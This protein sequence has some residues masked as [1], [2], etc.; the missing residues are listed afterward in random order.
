MPNNFPPV[1]VYP[2]G[3]DSDETLY[4]VFN[5][6]ET[7][8]T[9][10]NMPWSSDVAVAP[11]GPDDNEI[12]ANNGFANID[13]E[14]FYY[15]G[16]GYDENNK[17]NLLKHCCRNL[18]GSHTKHC[19]AGV[20]VRGFVVAEHHNQIADAIIKIEN[21]VGENFS[22]DKTTLDWKIRNLQQLPII[23]D[24]FTC[25]DVNFSF[26]II[27][28]D[29]AGG[30]L[31][32]YSVTITGT[33]TSYRL[34]FGDGE[35]TTSSTNGTHQYATNSV[36]DPIITIQNSKCTIVQSPIQRK[37]VKQPVAQSNP[38]PFEIPVPTVP[39]L[40]AFN[41]PIPA[42]PSNINV[43]PPIV[44]PCL[45]LAQTPV[46]PSVII[47]DNPIVFPSGISVTIPIIP[48]TISIVP[49]IPSTINFGPIPIPTRIMIGPISI[50]STITFGPVNIPSLIRFGPV[51]IPTLIK[52]GPVHIPTLIRFGPVNI[53]S[54][55]NF[56][57][58]NIPSVINFGPVSIPNYIQF[59]PLPDPIPPIISFSPVA[60]PSLISFTPINI[61]SVIEVIFPYGYIPDFI[62]F[63][64]APNIPSVIS[65][66]D[67]PKIP[68]VISFVSC[69]TIPSAISF[70]SC[71]YIPSVITFESC[72]V[73]PSVISF[74]SCCDIPSAISFIKPDWFGQGISIIWGQIPSQISVVCG[75]S[76]FRAA[77]SI[78][79]GLF[80]DFEP[81][82]I[83]AG[84]LGIPSQITIKAPEIPDI[85]LIHDVP[86]IIRI[87]PV[88]IPDIK[89]IGPTN[90]I[91][92]EIKILSDNIPSAIELVAK[93][94]PS[95]ITLDASG[96]PRSIKLEVPDVLPSI[97]IDASGIPDKIQVVGIPSAIELVGAPSEIKLVMPENPEIELVYKGAPIDVKINLDINKLT[98]DD[99]NGSCVAIV[100]CTPK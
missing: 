50:P 42:I 58:V 68:S 82:S 7:V 72:C 43:L 13:G 99:T 87:E 32:Q 31:A 76:G 34:D 52:F 9:T 28:E 75:A 92:T 77:N 36:I 47:I 14:L 54:L 56:G 57:L 2:N 84:D 83:D 79:D 45:S 37:Q 62:Y 21:F 69:C 30:I 100:P 19:P 26:V 93:D 61:P 55:I 4:L 49:P 94:I 12:W 59:S 97:K 40:P 66:V 46:F 17:I 78:Q 88:N 74:I 60:I 64:P 71:C 51:N 18:G 67:A 91:P 29:P 95:A 23:F 39:N 90:P 65:F 98:G 38:A 70:V 33:Y 35:Y 73:V 16:V 89:I 6:S 25:P 11:V 3:Y 41:I 81:V 22:S 8:T 15:D 80:D 20:D 1:S 48:S 24:D 27:S 86:A 63:G 44:F 85:K 53:P 96:L 10:E 5:S